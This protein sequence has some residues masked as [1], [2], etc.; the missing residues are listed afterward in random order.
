MDA[1]WTE[2]GVDAT[3]VGV[4]A[5]AVDA[6][7]D[8]LA[9]VEAAADGLGEVDAMADLDATAGAVAAV[10]ALPA[11]AALLPLAP[12]PASAAKTTT[13][14]AGA[15]GRLGIT[16]CIAAVW[17]LLAVAGAGDAIPPCGQCH[18]Q[19]C[20]NG[21][22]VRAGD[23]RQFGCPRLGGHRLVRFWGKAQEARL[24]GGA[25]VIA[26]A[27][28]TDSAEALLNE[29]ADIVLP[30]LRDTRAVTRAV[31]GIVR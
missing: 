22:R 11:P 26:V 13:N 16:I 21:V 9:D 23:P 27:T 29:G 1:P 18:Q 15:R 8:G 24:R 14:A 28:G 10:E 4:G 7:L 17:Q 5:D 25:R 6:A 20:S 31:A 12:H 2:R 19:A 30:D 3:A